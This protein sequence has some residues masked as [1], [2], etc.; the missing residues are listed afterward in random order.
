MKIAAKALIINDN[1]EILFI[2]RLIKNEIDYS[3][4]GGRIKEN[5]TPK[6]TLIRELKEELN[7]DIKVNEYFD[8]YNFYRIKD[9]VKV[10]CKTYHC[11]LLSNNL[12]INQDEDIEDVV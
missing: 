3:L 7:F 5:Q 4:P 6:E 9:N 12:K 11:K 8:E 2:K 1:K 10:L